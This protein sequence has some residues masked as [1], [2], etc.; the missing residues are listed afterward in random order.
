[1]APNGLSGLNKIWMR[2]VG[3]MRSGS[4]VL[5]NLLYRLRWLYC[6]Y[7]PQPS[8]ANSGCAL[9]RRPLA[10]PLTGVPSDRERCVGHHGHINRPIGS[11]DNG[12]SH[13]SVMSSVW[14]ST[15]TPGQDFVGFTE[16]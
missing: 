5:R 9:A 6:G 4:R 16:A 15:K 10:A 12:K 1:M 3:V 8:R 2:Y 7:E 14:T 13:R 11:F